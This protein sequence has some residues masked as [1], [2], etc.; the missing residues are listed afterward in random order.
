MKKFCF[1]VLLISVVLYGDWWDDAQGMFKDYKD[2]LY[3]TGG[4]LWA[5]DDAVSTDNRFN[6]QIGAGMVPPSSR[7][8]NVAGINLEVDPHADCKGIWLHSDFDAFFDDGKLWNWVTSYVTNT[9]YASL[10]TLLYSNNTVGQL[11]S[12]MQDFGVKNLQLTSERCNQ[13]EIIALTQDPTFQSMSWSQKLCVNARMTAGVNYPEAIKQCRDNAVDAALGNYAGAGTQ[14]EVKSCYDISVFYNDENFLK[15]MLGYY[16]PNTGGGGGFTYEYHSPSM[17]MNELMDSLLVLNTAYYDSIVDIYK[18]NIPGDGTTLYQ[19][20]EKY[21]QYLSPPGSPIDVE[22]IKQASN[23][24]PFEREALKTKIVSV[25][26]YAGAM[27]LLNR[28]ENFISSCELA[29]FRVNEEEP[30]RYRKRAEI[31]RAQM[32]NIYDNYTIM[33]DFTT[34]IHN[35]SLYLTSR[36]SGRFV[37]QVMSNAN[38]V[39]EKTVFGTPALHQ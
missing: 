7:K 24:P 2:E 19:K 28:I 32:R 5:W 37:E 20:L 25:G 4:A 6:Y 13:E 35:A 1:F 16:E 17:D 26:A 38:R 23:A 36:A 8:Y 31:L 30:E 11:H 27:F 9:V 3:S 14:A 33:S 15:A 10:M 12:F 29:D 21:V 34:S 18:G 22:A 39:G